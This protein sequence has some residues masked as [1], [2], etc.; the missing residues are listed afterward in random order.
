MDSS[1]Q[2][3]LSLYEAS[4]DALLRHCY[5]KTH[6]R[7]LAK[8]LVQESYL[9]TWRAI[10]S[11]QE[12]PNPPAF[13]Y[14]T[15][16][17]LIIDHYRRKKALSLDQLSE[18]GYD[19]LGTGKAEVEAPAEVREARAAI[20]RLEEPYRETMQLRYEDGFEVREIASMLGESENTISV[21]IHRALVRL[22]DTLT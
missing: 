17:N 16:N 8:D 3:F 20:A 18:S 21:R 2:Q 4:A 11:G 7:D 14:R 15:A 12:I 9:R 22:R 10:A 19:P 5:F 13:L 1:E 6:D